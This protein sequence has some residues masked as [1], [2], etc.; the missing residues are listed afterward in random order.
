MKN[1]HIIT[2]GGSSS[3]GKT[4]LANKLLETQN[5][6]YLDMSNSYHQ[7]VTSKNINEKNIFKY[8]KDVI[9]EKLRYIDRRV[10][11]LILNE[12]DDDY[13]IQCKLNNGDI[14][15]LSD[16]S[17][18]YLKIVLLICAIRDKFDLIIDNFDLCFIGSGHSK[19]IKMLLREIYMNKNKAIFTFT[20]LSQFQLF[21]LSIDKKINKNFYMTAYFYDTDKFEYLELDYA[22]LA[23]TINHI[24]NRE[25]RKLLDIDRD[26]DMKP[27]D[28]KDY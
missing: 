5:K 13:N 27:M 21:S 4:F 12:Y 3:T 15:N 11:E 2:I 26:I 28:L 23:F 1:S 22:K 7:L 9:F 8:N 16:I 18:K 25:A 6:L 14:V 10:E 20:D 19:I 24:Y 17:E